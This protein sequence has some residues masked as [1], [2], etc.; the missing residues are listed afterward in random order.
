MS[1][2]A[3][4]EPIH[5]SDKK[6]ISVASGS[7]SKKLAKAAKVSGGMA[8]GQS[9]AFTKHGLLAMSISPVTRSGYL[10][11]NAKASSPPSDQPSHSAFSGAT[12]AS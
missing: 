5:C 12:A 10:A 7:S 3:R 2:L 4:A 11:A 9:S 1:F 8:C 6:R